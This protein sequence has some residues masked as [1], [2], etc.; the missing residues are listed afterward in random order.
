MKHLMIISIVSLFSMMSFAGSSDLYIRAQIVKSGIALATPH[1]NVGDVMVEKGLDNN[2][3]ATY[4]TKVTAIN[5]DE[6]TFTESLVESGVKPKKRI[7]AVNLTT[8]VVRKIS[9]NGADDIADWEF[10]VKKSEKKTLSTVFGEK[11]C[12]VVTADLIHPDYRIQRTNTVYTFCDAIPGSGLLQTTIGF[13]WSGRELK[14][15][16]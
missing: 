5:K 12:T 16:L 4:V 1:F 3:Q 13:P 11:S 6:V 14:D 9:D 2:W 15:S 8:G 10:T 7:F